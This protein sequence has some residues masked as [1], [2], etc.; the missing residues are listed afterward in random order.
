[1]SKKGENDRLSD[2]GS[3]VE[4]LRREKKFTQ[5][6]IVTQMGDGLQEKTYRSWLKKR[7]TRIDIEHLEKLCKILTCDADFLMGK[8]TYKTHDTK[9]LCDTTGLSEKSAEML[10]DED[11][12]GAATVGMGID[13]LL[14]SAHA[15]EFL[16]CFIDYITYCDSKY[17]LV[18]LDHADGKRTEAFDVDSMSYNGMNVDSRIVMQSI[19]YRLQTVMDKIRIEMQLQESKPTKEADLSIRTTKP[20]DH[21]LFMDDPAPE[22]APK[23]APICPQ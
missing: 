2:F 7:G 5:K 14:S 18:F 23:S 22:V 15:A 12:P 21:V 11:Y 3:R 8:I 13:M 9:W 4:G 19:M 1:M 16:S 6:S 17:N 20:L 10:I